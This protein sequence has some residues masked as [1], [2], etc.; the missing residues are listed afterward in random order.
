MSL[1]SLQAIFY[2]SKFLSFP[3]KNLTSFLLAQ[4]CLPH[5]E[6][7]YFQTL[8][9]YSCSILSNDQGAETQWVQPDATTNILAR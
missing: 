4:T 6:V 9:A 8:M 5:R 2:D 1:Q 3:Q 7:K